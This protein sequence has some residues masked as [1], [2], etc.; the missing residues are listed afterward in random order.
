[1]VHFSST[2]GKLQTERVSYVLGNRKKKEVETNTKIVDL[3]KHVVDET[4]H[5]RDEQQ[6]VEFH[7]TLDWLL[8]A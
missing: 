6:R 3:L 4:K 5:C 7:I 1:V 2:S 8:E